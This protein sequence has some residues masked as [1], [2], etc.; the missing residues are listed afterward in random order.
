LCRKMSDRENILSDMKDNTQE[1]NINVPS[2]VPF[3]RMNLSKP[4]L[5]LSPPFKA[6]MVENHLTTI[7]N[8]T[9]MLRVNPKKNK[10]VLANGVSGHV[11]RR[12][13]A[14]YIDDL[15]IKVN[16]IEAEIAN[17]KQQVELKLNEKHSLLMERES[18]MG[19]VAIFQEKI[20]VNDAELEERKVEVKKLRE[21]ELQMLTNVQPMSNDLNSN[22]HQEPSQTWT[23]TELVPDEEEMEANIMELMKM[24]ENPNL[25]DLFP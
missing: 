14:Q 6:H 9:T 15:E 10:R 21:Q 20:L 17:L 24:P 8:P 16:E 3:S 2:F 23:P 5:C 12:K 19:Q 13:Q 1:N 4:P 7:N 18:L 25:N 11:P 22:Y